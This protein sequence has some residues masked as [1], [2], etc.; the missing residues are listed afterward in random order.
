MAN[1][2]LPQPIKDKIESEVED[3]DHKE[4]SISLYDRVSYRIGA[5]TWALRCMELIEALKA[6]EELWFDRN[7]PDNEGI[8]CHAC[9]CGEAG[10]KTNEDGHDFDCSISL[11]HSAIDKF[12][13]DMKE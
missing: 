7:L 3:I 6:S 4:D 11:A 1:V 13:K 12:N 2:T 9:D 5:T 8:A 10:D